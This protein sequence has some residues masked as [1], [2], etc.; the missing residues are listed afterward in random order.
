MYGGQSFDLEGNP[1]ILSD[2][3]V[4][5]PKNGGSWHK[6]INC[7]GEARQW[8]SA[9]Y[10][11]GRQQ[12]IAF[13]GESLQIGCKNKMDKV[14]T[15]DTLRVLDTEIM[16]WYPPAAS[17]DIPTGRSGHTATFFPETNELI[18]FGGV[19]GSKWLNSV[20]VLDVNR[21]IWTTPNIMG[22]APKP[23]SYH[24]ATAV[25]SKLVVF[26]GNN[27]N[28]CFNSV[29]VLEAI[30]NNDNTSDGSGNNG[31]NSTGWKWSNPTIF[32][33]APFPRTGHTA[34][35]LEDGK[36]IIVY[37]G[38]DPNEED[39]LTGEDN[40]FKGT[41]MLDTQEWTWKE[42]PNP[43]SCG[44]ASAKHIVQ[45]CGP[46]RCGHTSTLNSENG[47]VFVFGGRIPGELLAG[48]VQVLVPPQEKAM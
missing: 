12:L 39:E 24:S 34:T 43:Q 26:G 46:K 4:Y 29:H 9:T 44:G 13:G 3:H 19:R 8:H 20:T 6:P 35:L 31:G 40:I 41:Y 37:G 47:E 30:G 23:R 21:W 16:L 45:D 15:S 32:G 10:I 17:G 38:W 33:K 11:P 14:V 25:G 18:L 7:R 36:T 48:D 1:V 22:T 2:V 28:S 5:D 42:G 27:K